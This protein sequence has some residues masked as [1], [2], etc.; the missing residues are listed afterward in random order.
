MS[1]NMYYMEFVLRIW[2]E[3]YFDIKDFNEMFKTTVI[4]I[5]LIN[6]NCLLIKILVKIEILY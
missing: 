2:E 6:I 3:N 4:S 1:I 5:I